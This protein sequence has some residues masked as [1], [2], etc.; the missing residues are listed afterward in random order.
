MNAV[1][2]TH[3]QLKFKCKLNDFRNYKM[4][5]FIILIFV[6]IMFNYSN[7][8]F[9]N[10]YGSKSGNKF[11]KGTKLNGATAYNVANSYPNN[12]YSSGSSNNNDIP[13][14]SLPKGVDYTL[15]HANSFNQAKTVITKEVIE[16]PTGTITKVTTTQHEPSSYR[17]SYGR[18]KREIGLDW[19][20]LD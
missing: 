4:G 16:S 8:Q 9:G 15:N 20:I 17:N 2:F 12:V 18:K 10:S 5:K 7:C 6:L 1:S 13:V 19:N 11:G 3:H 14:V